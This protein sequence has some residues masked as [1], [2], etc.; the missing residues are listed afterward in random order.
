MGH[1]VSL[2][3]AQWPDFEEQYT[4]DDVIAIPVQVN[5][6]VRGRLV[7]SSSAGG[8]QRRL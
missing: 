6:R 4:R 3:Y 8:A 7:V 1:T 2:A 5:G